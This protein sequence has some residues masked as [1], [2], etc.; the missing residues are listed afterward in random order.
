MCLILV[1]YTS[2]KYFILAYDTHLTGLIKKFYRNQR[3]VSYFLPIK[4]YIIKNIVL[5][6]VYKSVIL[7]KVFISLNDLSSYKNDNYVH[8]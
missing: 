5:I 2:L 3:H 6:Y 1:Q 4:C 7:T 8:Y